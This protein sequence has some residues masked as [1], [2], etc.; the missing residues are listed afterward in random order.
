M[1]EAKIFEPIQMSR[2]VMLVA[3]ICGDGHRKYL[4]S[5]KSPLS[6]EDTKALEEILERVKAHKMPGVYEGRE[7]I[8]DAA[9]TVLSWLD[10]EDWHSFRSILF[11]TGV[12]EGDAAR[13]ISQTAEQL[14]QLIHLSESHPK[15][16]QVAE[17]SRNRLLRPPLTELF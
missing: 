2:L 3:A 13:L 12:T 14:N 1:V 10:A 9:Y 7:V 6:A 5:K 17:Y 16:A 8:P 4:H 15:L 11:L